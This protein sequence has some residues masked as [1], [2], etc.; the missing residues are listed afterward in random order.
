MVYYISGI[1]GPCSDLSV[2]GCKYLTAYNITI[3]SVR[4]NTQTNSMAA[5][6]AQEM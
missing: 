4:A 1:P 2:I 6:H 3:G 5:H